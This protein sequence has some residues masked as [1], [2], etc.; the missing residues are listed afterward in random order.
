MKK[1]ALCLMTACLLLTCNP[2]QST[3]AT[4][5]APSALVAPK[6]AESK[7]AKTLLLRLNEIK[8]MDKS[9]LNSSEKKNLRKEVRE[10]RSELRTS[11]GG[12]YLSVGAILIII[13]LLI[14]LL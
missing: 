1:I 6:H 5:T 7:E 9:N 3:A 12:I 11:N 10:I 2:F 13:L 14:I 4:T 8:D